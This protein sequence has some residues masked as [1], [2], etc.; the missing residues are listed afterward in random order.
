MPL[1][2]QVQEILSRENPP[3]KLVD[4]KQKLTRLVLMSRRTMTQYYPMW[5]RNDAVYRGER[6]WDEQDRKAQKRNEPE[7][8]FVPLTHSQ[9][10]TFVAFAT[11][12]LSQRDYFLSWR[13]RFSNAT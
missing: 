6:Q 13:R 1:T 12:L 7:K 3:Q 4:F 10:Q 9:T 5:D 11:M 8:V 2:P